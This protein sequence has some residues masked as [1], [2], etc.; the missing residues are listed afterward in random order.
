MIVS[1]MI[2]VAG[3]A[4]LLVSG[5]AFSSEQSDVAVNEV[6]AAETNLEASQEADTLIYSVRLRIPYGLST[7]T[8]DLGADW[9]A[10][11]VKLRYLIEPSCRTPYMSLSLRSSVDGTWHRTTRVDTVDT[12]T[13][14]SFDAVR[15]ELDS[16]WFGAVSCE[17][18][19]FGASEPANDDWGVGVLAGGVE[20]NGGF[21]RDLELAVSADERIKGFR[22]AI[23]EFCGRAEI[24]E[25]GTVTEGL[26][27][28]ATLLDAGKM[29]YQ[30]AGSS[31]RATKIRLTVN[32]PFDSRCFIP[33]YVYSAN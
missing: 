12:H 15:F 14:S 24:L 29:I 31:V 19:L 3:S 2:A 5:L 10:N 4:M 30:V 21:G 28:P 16:P 32:G 20:Y 26:F 27:D 33:V 1:K 7:W 23:P 13:L 6:F 22:I 25:A 17:I 18:A 11:P 9:T 8:A